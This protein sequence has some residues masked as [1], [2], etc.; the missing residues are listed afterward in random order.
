MYGKHRVIDDAHLG[1]QCDTSTNENALC[2]C[3]AVQPACHLVQLVHALQ[4]N[5]IQSSREDWP[6]A[7]RY[8]PHGPR[9]IPGLCG[10]VLAPCAPNSS[11]PSLSWPP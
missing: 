9:G 4:Q 3:S 6:D 10:G 7:Y 8:T 11:L 2:L 1:G 5:A